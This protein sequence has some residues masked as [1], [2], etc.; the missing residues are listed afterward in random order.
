MFVQIQ[1]PV[2]GSR[3]LTHITEVQGMEAEFVTP[4]IAFV[5]KPPDEDA[6][7]AGGVVKLLN[8]LAC[9]GL[10]PH[11]LDKLEAHGVSLPPDFFDREEE[12]Q[13]T[14]FGTGCYGSFS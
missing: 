10:K 9:L 6:A 7:A 3:R 2:D 5:A 14:A 13:R 4:Q 8:P 12:G 11:F 1:F